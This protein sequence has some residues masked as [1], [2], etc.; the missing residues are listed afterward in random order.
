MSEQYNFDEA[1]INDLALT[2]GVDKT[3]A[4][5]EFV[6]SPEGSNVE[7]A[8]ATTTINGSVPESK[9]HNI[10]QVKDEDVKQ[11]KRDT[12]AT[13]PQKNAGSTVKGAQATSTF[14][15]LV[16][17]IPRVKDEDVKQEK[18]DAHA[19]DPRNNAGS[20]NGIPKSQ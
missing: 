19:T 2:I 15:G 20:T 12:H 7:G 4:M 10:L 8:Q 5:C 6:R 11:G 14:K 16:Y 17:N 3:R 9:G 1:S 18:H 13:D